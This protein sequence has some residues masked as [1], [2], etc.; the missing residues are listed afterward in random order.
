MTGSSD[1]ARSPV[2]RSVAIVIP[3]YNEQRNIKRLLT[4]IHGQIGVPWEVAVVDQQSTDRTREIARAYGCTVLEVP[5]PIFYTPPGRNR[6]LGAGAV[7]G[8]I[9]LHLDADMELPSSTFLQRLVG[10]IDGGHQAAVIHELDVATGFW[11]KCKALER[12]CYW[13]S[14]IESARA[15]TRS[16]FEKVGGYDES[17]SS[18]EDFYISALYRLETSIARDNDLVL[19]HHTGRTSLRSLLS[20]KFRYGKSAGTYL[21]K[22]RQAGAVSGATLAFASFIAYLANVRLLTHDPIHYC[23]IFPLR[24]MEFIAIR[25]GIWVGPE[26]VVRSRVGS[27]S[28][29]ITKRDRV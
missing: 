4:S 25:L 8:E 23:C 11:N 13:N 3:T 5:R 9:L 7:N 28:G 24:F 29:E 10:L 20:K 26:K 12:R 17:I 27:S 15:V 6:N 2:S 21:R 19:L 16:L 18:G 14:P 1:I 22:A